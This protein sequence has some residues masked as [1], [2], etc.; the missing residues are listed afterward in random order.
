MPRRPEPRTVG[1][2]H[3]VDQDDAAVAV[4][5]EFKLGIG[6]DDALSQRVI[7]GTRVEGNRCVAYLDGEGLTDDFDHARE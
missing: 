3:L 7:G 2:H 1:G 4:A 6:D 5:A